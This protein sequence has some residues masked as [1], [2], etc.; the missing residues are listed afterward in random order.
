MSRRTIFVLAGALL[1]AAL[2]CGYWYWLAGTVERQVAD[3]ARPG[4]RP[5]RLETAAAQV[6]GFPATL[7]ITLD[8]PRLHTPDGETWSAGELQARLNP[9]RPDRLHILV[10]P[11]VRGDGPLALHVESGTLDLALLGEEREGT[12]AAATLSLTAHGG[13]QLRVEGLVASARQTGEATLLSVG[14]EAVAGSS[15][16]LPTGTATTLQDLAGQVSLPAPPPASLDVAGLVAWRDAGGTLEIETLR[17]DWQ[18]MTV[19]LEATLA[20]DGGLRPLGAGTLRLHNAAAALD[21]LQR[22]G[23]LSGKEVERW[24]LILAALPK[25]DIDGK[26]FVELPLAAQDGLLYV[27][28]FPVGR[29]PSVASG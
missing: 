23:L 17:F 29:L 28:P 7:R 16:I 5:V 6:T 8:A 4:R 21:A 18:A 1:L 9:L 15:G 2:W 27:G 14:A 12:L 11:E 13:E 22:S 26:S 24:R 10:P 19:S 3:L 25:R 20:L